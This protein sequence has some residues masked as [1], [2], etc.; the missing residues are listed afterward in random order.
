MKI[1]TNHV[2][3]P[4]KWDKLC[5]LIKLNYVHLKKIMIL[6]IAG[7][8]LLSHPQPASAQAK[9]PVKTAENEGEYRVN[10]GIDKTIDKGFDKIEE[11]IGSLFKKGM[12]KKADN[13]EATYE[14]QDHCQRD[15]F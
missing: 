1:V 15:P 14:R 11:G 8:F 5:D 7:G 13:G 12:K 4:V 9:D 10:R 6:L 2:G 3:S